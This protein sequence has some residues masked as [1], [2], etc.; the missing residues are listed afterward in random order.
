MFFLEKSHVED[1]QNRLIIA[2]FLDSVNGA[3]ELTE[4]VEK[5]HFLGE[6]HDTPEIHDAVIQSYGVPLE[7]E[8]EQDIYLFNVPDKI[9]H[10]KKKPIY[11]DKSGVWDV[12]NIMS[13][14]VDCV[15]TKFEA[16]EH[17]NEFRYVLLGGDT[18][19]T[20]VI[21]VKSALNKCYFGVNA[22]KV[23]LY[24]KLEKNPGWPITKDKMV[25]LKKHDTEY[26]IR[27]NA[28]GRRSLCC[29]KKLF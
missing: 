13:F 4:Y 12:R 14:V 24:K 3:V 16:W 15:F 17:E 29:R 2:M 23:A 1:F 26:R 6:I 18:R 20:N 19:K 22:E 21:C 27:W 5:N 9:V 11:N 25:Q 7:A 28:S 10:E 8:K